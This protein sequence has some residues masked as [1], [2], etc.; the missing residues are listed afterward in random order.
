MIKFFKILNL[1]A[2]IVS[3]SSVNTSKSWV[4]SPANESSVI[5]EQS[6]AKFLKD[7]L[8]YHEKE[9]RTFKALNFPI[10]SPG[11]VDSRGAALEVA[12]I[13]DSPEFN[14][15]WEIWSFLYDLDN[16]TEN[17]QKFRTV[18]TRGFSLEERNKLLNLCFLGPAATG[19]TFYVSTLLTNSMC[20]FATMF[21]LES[22]LINAFK[23]FP[24][25]PKGVKYDGSYGFHIYEDKVLENKVQIITAAINTNRETVYKLY[26]SQPDSIKS[27]FSRNTSGSAEASKNEPFDLLS[28]YSAAFFIRKNMGADHDTGEHLNK[29]QISKLSQKALARFFHMTKKE[30][31]S[32]NTTPS[33]S[34][35]KTENAV[36]IMCANGMFPRRDSQTSGLETW[37]RGELG[38]D[39]VETWRPIHDLKD[40]VKKGFSASNLTC[41]LL[42]YRFLFQTVPAE[43][44][45]PPPELNFSGRT[46]IH[47]LMTV[48]LV[49]EIDRSAVDKAAL[50]VKSLTGWEIEEDTVS[51][52]TFDYIRENFS[53]FDLYFPVMH[54]MDVNYFNVGTTSSLLVK[55]KKTV[56][57]NNGTKTTMHLHVLLPDG[58]KTFESLIFKPED[59]AELLDL[60]YQTQKSPLFIMNNSCAS[61]K[62]LFAWTLVYRKA[63]KLR[64]KRIMR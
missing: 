19:D 35:I 41:N 22:E 37:Y 45:P 52:K 49:S 44:I 46:D 34:V 36:R 5:D 50:F 61:E 62:T 15:S 6:V 60:R 16:R 9:S 55:I 21:H 53:K 31:D 63:L 57:R 42:D 54:S 58:S 43:I 7:L 33:L 28:T 26:H 30:H 59:L 25:A 8:A 13:F 1:F 47:G 32:I 20:Q 39:L 3:C 18:I 14:G 51:V 40:F 24:A 4:R 38:T 56:T 48:S 12:R 29:I 2:I 27:K 11:D 10:N 23:E 64:Q 17:L